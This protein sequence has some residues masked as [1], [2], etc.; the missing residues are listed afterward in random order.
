MEEISD[1]CLNSFGYKRTEEYPGLEYICKNLLELKIE[2]KDFRKHVR[3]FAAWDDG[4]Q[5]FNEHD[6]ARLKIER[7][8]E[9]A[10]FEDQLKDPEYYWLQDQ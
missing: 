6:Y 10:Y 3:A 7:G 9:E 4:S 1:R 5:I 8:E 2:K